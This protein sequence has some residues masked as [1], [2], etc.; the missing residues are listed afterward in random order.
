M[1]FICTLMILSEFME[2]VLHVKGYHVNTTRWCYNLIR[3]N[4]ISR[5]F[6]FYIDGIR[7]GHWSNNDSRLVHRRVYCTARGPPL[8]LRYCPPRE[9]NPF[10]GVLLGVSLPVGLPPRRLQIPS[11]GI[12][13]GQFFSSKNQ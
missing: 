10:T 9:S 11:L 4:Y 8:I 12:P 7:A 2:K 6:F 13:F 1:R 3:I 5:L